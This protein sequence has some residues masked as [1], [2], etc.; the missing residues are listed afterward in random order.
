MRNRLDNTNTRLLCAK[1]VKKTPK[2]VYRKQ[3]I[4]FL[5]ITTFNSKLK[6]LVN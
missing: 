6:K 4:F 2:K 1:S 5:S 3:V